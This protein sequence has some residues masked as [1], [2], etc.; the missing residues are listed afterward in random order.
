MIGVATIIHA[1][2]HHVVP[3]YTR[4]LAANGMRPTSVYAVYCDADDAVRNARC[5][6]RVETRDG[7]CTVTLSLHRHHGRVHSVVRSS[8]SARLR[9]DRGYYANAHATSYGCV[10]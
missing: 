7:S 6:I 8:L 4:Q 2:D 10:A 9:L 5:M 1:V 3:A